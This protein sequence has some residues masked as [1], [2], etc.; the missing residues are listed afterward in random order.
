M[1]CRASPPK[2][3]P[4]P[5]SA[6]LAGRWT[7]YDERNGEEVVLN[8]RDV[9][10]LRRLRENKFPHPEFDAY[11]DY[12]RDTEC[13]AINPLTSHSLSHTP[14]FVFSDPLLYFQEGNPPPL[15]CTRAKA[16]IPALQV[17]GKT[18]RP[19]AHHV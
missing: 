3:F 11:P 18:R 4:A 7:I 17:G 5:S 19:P 6:R 8:P 15:Q 13:L 14:R 2:A 1:A 16:S 10:L 9:E 12:V